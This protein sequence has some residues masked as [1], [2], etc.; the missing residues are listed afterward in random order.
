MV[1]SFT[2]DLERF[3]KKA[4]GNANKIVRKIVFDMHSRIVERTPVDTGR[5]KANNQ[6]CLHSIPHTSVMDVDKSGNATIMKGQ[7]VMSRFNLGDTVFIYN[8]LEYIIALEYGHS[9]QQAPNG[10]FRITFEEVFNHLDKG[11]TPL[12]VLGVLGL[13]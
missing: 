9:R 11:P 3:G 5:A 7:T 12:D 1:Q 13:K 8:N 4:I 6:V 2:L 10:M